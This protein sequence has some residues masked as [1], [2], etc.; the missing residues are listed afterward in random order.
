MKKKRFAVSPIGV[1]HTPYG[2]PGET[3]IQGRRRPEGRGEV[4]VFEE[5]AAGLQDLD[6]FS[7]IILLYYFHRAGQTALLV[8]PFLDDVA[9][10]VFATRHPRRPNHIGLA[11]V[12]LLAR[13]GNF[14]DVAGV[15]MFNGTPLV[16]IKPY[17]PAFDKQAGLVRI[18][19]LEGKT[20]RSSRGK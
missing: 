3:P 16:D 19:W 11:V 15:D 14:L 18:G 10:G 2:E 4:E 12:R 13:R 8:K 5:Y 6:G 1:I 7:H 20:E 9:R 17:V